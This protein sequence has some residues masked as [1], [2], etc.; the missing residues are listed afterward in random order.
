MTASR[1]KSIIVWRLQNDGESLGKAQRRL[2][3]HSH[4]VSDITLSSDGQ[5]CLSGSWDGT[6]R[7]WDLATGET[8]RHFGNAPGSAGHTKD[9]LS[10]AFSVDNRQIV[11]GSRDKTVKLWNT[12][13]EGRPG[14]RERSPH[15]PVLRLLNSPS[16]AH[17]PRTLPH[18]TPLLLLRRVQ[19]HD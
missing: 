5:Y 7:L 13:G 8:T 19:A 3:G 18:S 6:L 17:A 14:V 9:V 2:Q 12:I 1:D 16:L 10:V 15:R 11:S 4:F